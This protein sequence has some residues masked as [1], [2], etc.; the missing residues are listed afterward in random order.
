MRPVASGAL[1]TRRTIATGSRAAP[2]RTMP[3]R[4]VLPGRPRSAAATPAG[5]VAGGGA[6]S[7]LVITSPGASPAASAGLPGNTSTTRTAC[8]CGS[9]SSSAP[10]PAAGLPSRKP[11]NFL[12]A[13]GRNSTLY[14]SCSAASSLSIVFATS[15]PVR[16]R[17]P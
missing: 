11:T 6:P 17:V 5:V 7:M 3:R 15:S 9:T 10:I 1:T 12:N 4:T 16:T 13:G 8:V 2:S 14:G